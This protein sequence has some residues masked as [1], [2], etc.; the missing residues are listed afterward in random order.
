MTFPEYY[1]Q[2][3]NRADE[4]HLRHAIIKATGATKDSFYKWIYNT[5]IPYLKT[6]EIIAEI[7]G[8][9]REEL[10]PILNKFEN[11]KVLVETDK[12]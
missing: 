3:P 10:F 9:P 2:L 7:I 12:K 6:Q 4:K 8:L 11:H 5:S 1:K